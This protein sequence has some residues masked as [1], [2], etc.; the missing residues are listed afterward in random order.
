[1]N[2]DIESVK[3]I[4][5]RHK[6]IREKIDEFELEIQHLE[7]TKPENGYMKID[8]LHKTIQTLKDELNL[9]S[10]ILLTMTKH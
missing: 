9:Y 2:V 7:E 4:K 1:M 8:N 10:D 5:R 3:F 6:V